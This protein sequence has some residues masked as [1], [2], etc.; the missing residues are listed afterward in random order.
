MHRQ[1]IAGSAFGAA[2][3]LP[4]LLGCSSSEGTG[5]SPG[6]G[7]NGSGTSGSGT[8]ATTTTGGMV[9]AAG[10]GVV[11][12][13]GTTS[14]GGAA[15][16]NGTGTAGSFVGGGTGGGPMVMPLDCGKNGTA[17]EQ[18]GPPENRLNYVIV[19]DGYSEVEL[20]PGGALDKHLEA[21]LKKRFSDPI[22]QPFLRYRKFINICVLRIPSSPICGSSEF[23]CCGNDQS[24]LAN[25]D[26]QAVN[27]AI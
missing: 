5:D 18:H 7:G 23:G 19:G 6:A 24:R 26:T 21:M 4:F 9:G 2:L 22:G 27:S 17:L 1:I 20:M 12:P 25:C 3:L 8:G 16:T 13:G 15:G 10:S 14:A 11:G